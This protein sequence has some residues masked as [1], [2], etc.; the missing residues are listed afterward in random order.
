VQ[1][2]K[3]QKVIL[4]ID[5]DVPG[6]ETEIIAKEILIKNKI[7][8][9]LLETREKDLFRELHKAK[10]GSKNAAYAT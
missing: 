1:S 6:R 2:I 5:R 10:G 9:E 7:D 4:A 3:P 8:Y